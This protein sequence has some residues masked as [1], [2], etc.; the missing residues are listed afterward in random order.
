MR[1]GMWIESWGGGRS[2]GYGDPIKDDIG[3][4]GGI[5]DEKGTI[6]PVWGGV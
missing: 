5:G 2:E 4:N 3:V 1:E 6:H